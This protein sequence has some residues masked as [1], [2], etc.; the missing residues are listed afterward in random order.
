MRE[1]VEKEHNARFDRNLRRDE[2]DRSRAVRR[3]VER[4]LA[5]CPFG[6]FRAQML[7]VASGDGAA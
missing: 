1:I 6:Q 3:S 2:R 7:R 5:C 4:A